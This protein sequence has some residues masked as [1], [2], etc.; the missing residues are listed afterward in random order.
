MFIKRVYIIQVLIF[1]LA[2]ST[3]YSCPVETE[4]IRGKVCDQAYFEDGCPAD[5]PG[6]EGV[7]VSNQREVVL[8]DQNGYFE[9]P[10]EEEMVVYVSKPADYEYPVDDQNLPVFYYIHQPDGSPEFLEFAGLEPTG[11]LPE[12]VDFA[13]VPSEVQTEFTA[14]VFG[15]PQPRDHTEL[16]WYR[17]DVVSELATVDADMTMVL[18]DIMFDDLTLFGRYNQIMSTVGMPVFNIVGNHDLNFDADQ[19][20]PD[21]NR[22][23]RETYKSYYGPTYYSFGHGDVHFIV[24]DN[25]DYQGRS[26]ETGRA[27]YVGYL[28]ETHLAWMENTLSHVPE[29][30][31]IVL[32]SHIPLYGMEHERGNINTLNREDLFALLESYD[33]VLY[34]GGHRH[35]TYQHFLGEE[36]GRTN[37]NPIHHVAATAACGS[38]WSGPVQK[39]GVPVTTQQD[40]VPNGYH[41]FTFNGNTY[42]ERY[43]AAG[44]PAEY[45][46]R[47]E[48][49]AGSIATEELEE[50]DLMVNVFNGSERSEVRYQINGGDWVEMEREEVAYSPFF[51]ELYAD[52]QRSATPTNHIWS[53]PMPDLSEGVHRIT[54]W[55]RDMYGQEF[56]QTKVVEVHIGSASDEEE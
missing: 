37:P 48:S 4:N 51:T 7:M 55:T 3:A 33:D 50:T 1:I 20:D 14:V 42:T 31:L 12:S 25:M 18:G 30:Q 16:S 5:A 21:P 52:Y 47:I 56:T 9:L 11:S 38:W 10:I 40:G 13:L 8:T 39:N 49:P 26:E 29:D 24:M 53:A 17:D 27:Q 23:A 19:L 34:L 41:L 2:Y 45:Q 15:D 46:M 6:I 43:K 35:L 22:F 32:M 44:L 28:D 54:A 36:F